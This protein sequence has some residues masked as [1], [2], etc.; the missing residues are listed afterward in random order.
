MT[1]SNS[2]PCRDAIYSDDYYDFIIDYFADFP[3]EEAACFQKVSN[4]FDIAYY[5][6]SEMPDL[7][8]E[9][10]PYSSIP[11]CFALMNETA[12][13]DS[14]ILRLQNPAG[15]DLTGQ[16]ILV[17]FLDTGIEYTHPAFYYSDG[18]TRIAAI[19][20]QTA[21]DG[22]PPE[23]F[24]YGAFYDR[25]AV[26]AAL[27]SENPLE[28][29]PVTDEHGHGTFLAGVACG[30]T[31]AAADFTGAAP[32]SEILVVKCKEAKPYLREYYYVPDGVPVFQEND[33]MLALSWLIRMAER[34]QKPLV[35]CIGMGTAIG[36]H[37]GEDAISIFCDEIGRL[38]QQCIVTCAGNE[39][40]ARHHYYKSGMRENETDAI[41]I[42]VGDGVPGFFMECWAAVPEIYRVAIVS[43]SGERFVGSGSLIGR[44]THEFLFEKTMLTVDYAVTGEN[45]R[46]Q[47]IR[48]AF[49]APYSGVWTVQ[50]TS[51]LVLEGAFHCWLPLTDLLKGEVVFLRSDPDTTILSPGMS[52]AAVCVGAYQTNGD[53]IWPA[54]GRGY[55]VSGTVKPDVLAPGVNVYGPGLRDSYTVRTGTSIGAAVTAGACAQLFQWGILQLGASWLNSVSLSNFLIRGARRNDGRAYPNHAYGYGFLDAY[56]ALEVLR[57]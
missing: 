44:Q 37:A 20:D 38:R 31:N 14:G 5:P 32:L 45:M 7:S 23:G 24:S 39:A 15:L 30:S 33:L 36:S 25:D 1:D 19:W 52:A 28:V 13:E 10:Y 49:F 2:F 34:L 27:L 8:P 46:N 29:V 35:I 56:G 48:L 9:E 41:E 21:E 50:L 53:A 43:P 54:S 17:G 55:S 47:L 18:M 51:V 40:N 3:M 57:V 4:R 22:V 16:G 12:L 6:R 11:K 26:N 42:S